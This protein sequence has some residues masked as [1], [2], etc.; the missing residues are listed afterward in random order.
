MGSTLISHVKVKVDCVGYGWDCSGTTEA[1]KGL[2]GLSCFNL[3][4]NIFCCVILI[5]NHE[6]GG[7]ERQHGHYG[8]QNGDCKEDN[9]AE[10][11]G[12][13]WV[14]WLEVE[15]GFYG[16]DVEVLEDTGDEGK[17]AVTIVQSFWRLGGAVPLIF[18]GLSVL[19]LVVCE[20]EGSCVCY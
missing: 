10:T 2:E 7:V 13:G 15:I 5:R 11:A 8:E 14:E 12:A 17:E 6:F 9:G 1:Q 16:K 4:I 3:I 18:D 19:L 20:G